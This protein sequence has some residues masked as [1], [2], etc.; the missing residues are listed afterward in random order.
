[1]TIPFRNA[2]LGSFK[3]RDKIAMS[4]FTPVTIDNIFKTGH[5]LEQD[6]SFL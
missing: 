4:F 6:G 1:M 2:L 3:V 5:I